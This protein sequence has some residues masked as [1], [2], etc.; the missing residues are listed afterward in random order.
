[1]RRTLGHTHSV[2]VLTLVIVSLKATAAINTIP[3][4]LLPGLLFPDLHSKKSVMF[5]INVK[6]LNAV[7]GFSHAQ[8]KDD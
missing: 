7:R 1:M 5:F 2:S 3:L 4:T 8:S 6:T